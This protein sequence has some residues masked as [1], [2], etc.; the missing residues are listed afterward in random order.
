[1]SRDSRDSGDITRVLTR[2]SDGDRSAIPRLA[3]LVYDEMRGL[4]G[5]YLKGE[6]PGHTLQATELVHEAFLKL[7]GSTEI[8]W[9][10][11][12]HFYAVGAQAMRR[13]LVDHA[14]RKKSLKRGGNV[15]KVSLEEGQPLTLSKEEDILAVDEALNRLAA[16]NE[17]HARIVELRFFG[18]LKVE[19]VAEAL[20][21]GRRTVEA[22]WT[23][24]R[25]WLRRE[26]AA[27][28]AHR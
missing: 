6:A 20:A 27:P 21:I 17:R 5:K 22:D 15:P 14:R 13:I 8:D 18:G 10:G 2:V 16:L 26:L 28:D 4:A 23:F 7:V 19:E 3:S 12:T 1:M 25:A 11:R 24:A 9:R